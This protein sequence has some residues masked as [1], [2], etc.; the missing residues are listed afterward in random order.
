MEVQ[1]PGPPWDRRLRL[2]WPEWLVTY[3]DCIWLQMVICLS[4]NRTRRRVTSLMWPTLLPL[5]QTA[6]S[7]SGR[8][9]GSMVSSMILTITASEAVAECG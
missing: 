5:G 3:Q 9:V 1:P 2:S 8:Q 7:F 4:T 6:I